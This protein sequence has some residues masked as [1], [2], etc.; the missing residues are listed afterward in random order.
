[1]KAFVFP[2]QGSQYPGMGKELAL[3]YPEAKEAFEEADDALGIALSELCFEGPAEE[4]TLTEN[5]PD[6]I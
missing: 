6:P 5:T 3:T 2:G 1:M 4:L